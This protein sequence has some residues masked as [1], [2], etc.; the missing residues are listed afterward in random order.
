MPFE[1]TLSANDKLAYV[2]WWGTAQRTSIREVVDCLLDQPRFGPGFVVLYDHHDAV[3]PLT[4]DMIHHAMGLFP[5]EH[6]DCTWVFVVSNEVQ[7]EQL[8]CG[9]KKLS[10]P[11][12]VHVFTDAHAAVTWAQSHVPQSR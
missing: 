10:L 8:R 9:L 7:A 3:G 11:V 1:M 5:K 12:D 2:R 6:A 4:A